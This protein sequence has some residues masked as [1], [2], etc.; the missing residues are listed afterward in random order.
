[1][2]LYRVFI[3]DNQR[4]TVVYYCSLQYPFLQDSNSNEQIISIINLRVWFLWTIVYGVSGILTPEQY[5]STFRF[6]YK[7]I[8]DSEI[9][10]YEEHRYV[11]CFHNAVIYRLYLIVVFL[12][13]LAVSRSRETDLCV[14]CFVLFVSSP[15]HILCLTVAS[16]W[17]K[18]R[19]IPEILPLLRHSTF[20]SVLGACCYYYLV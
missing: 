9:K 4:H 13:C 5:V 11:T 20:C 6:A 16:G 10:A 12:Q 15:A 2:S 3:R 1:M 17:N 8:Y 19:R 18:E 7:K 14:L